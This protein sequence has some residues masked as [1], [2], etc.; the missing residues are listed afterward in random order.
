[1]ADRRERIALSSVATW[2]E[3]ESRCP[4]SSP[5]GWDCVGEGSGVFEVPAGLLSK[6]VFS[7]ETCDSEEDGGGP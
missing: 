3:R 4:S 2:P 5:H 7:D 6:Y 1:M